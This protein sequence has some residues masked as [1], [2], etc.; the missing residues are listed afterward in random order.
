MDI[1]ISESGRIEG[2][3]SSIY[4]VLHYLQNNW[5]VEEIA[6][7]LGLSVDQV[8]AAIDH[9]AQNKERVM[10]VHRE[11]EERIARGNPPDVLDKL[12]DTRARMKEWLSERKRVAAQEANG[13]GNPGRRE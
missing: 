12:A 5:Q 1:T 4:E 10:A 3:R 13:V 2:T 11:I 8:R 6:V 7:S 9:I